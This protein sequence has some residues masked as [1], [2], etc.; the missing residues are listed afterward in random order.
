MSRKRGIGATITVIAMLAAGCTAG[1]DGA[2]LSVAVTTTPLGDVARNL[3][4]DDGV[5]EVLLPIG[6]D[7]HSYQPSSQQVAVLHGSDLVVSNGLGLEEALHD[8]LKAAEADGVNVFEVAPLLDPIPFADDH[9][10]EGL[11]PHVWHDPVRMAEAA[12]L[13]AA[14]LAAIDPSVDWVGR[15]EEY[16]A[17]LTQADAD[18]TTILASIADQRRT[19]VTNHEAFG[20]FAARYGFQIIGVVIPGGSTLADPSSADLADLVEIVRREQVPAIFAETSQPT[21]LAEAVAA[22]VGGGVEVVEL[23]SESLGEPGSGADT[24]VGMLI[25]NATLIADA[26]G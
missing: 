14:E 21:S 19:L 3:V 13:I 2:E 7:S 12:R 20:Y 18:V 10:H 26:L 25:S 24:L 17:Q 16:A 23:Y 11:D 4:R 9:G 15:A 1:N 5:V 8:V 6:A 22:E